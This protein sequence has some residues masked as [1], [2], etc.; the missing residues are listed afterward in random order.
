MPRSQAQRRR[1]EANAYPV[2]K[3]EPCRVALE[4]LR[5][6]LLVHAN[7]HHGAPQRPHSGLLCVELVDVGDAAGL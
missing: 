3:V 6:A 4:E 7:E 5:P 1:G 2:A